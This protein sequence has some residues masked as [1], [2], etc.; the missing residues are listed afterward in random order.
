MS[1]LLY[2][3][4]PGDFSIKN[5]RENANQMH[6]NHYDKDVLLQPLVWLKKHIQSNVNENTVKSFI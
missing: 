1:I 6:P 5:Q 4:K 3:R 2:Y